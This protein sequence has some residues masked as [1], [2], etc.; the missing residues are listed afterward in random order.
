M[1]GERAG[2][3][4]ASTCSFTTKSVPPYLLGVVGSCL[5]MAYLLCFSRTRFVCVDTWHREGK[6][7]LCLRGGWYIKSFPRERNTPIPEGVKG[8]NTVLTLAGTTSG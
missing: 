3:G 2:E 7:F 5:I 8:M 1:I 6:D 4:F